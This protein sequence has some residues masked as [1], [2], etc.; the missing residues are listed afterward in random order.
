M[1]I[2]KTWGPEERNKRKRLLTRAGS[3]S[4]GDNIPCEDLCRQ[5]VWTIERDSRIKDLRFRKQAFEV[6][7]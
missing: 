1:V 7:C 2:F 6:V 4:H 3:H 5:D